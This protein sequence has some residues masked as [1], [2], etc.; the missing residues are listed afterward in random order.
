MSTLTNRESVERL[1]H[2]HEE[3]ARAGSGGWILYRKKGSQPNKI[4]TR[5]PGDANDHNLRTG[6]EESSAGIPQPLSQALI[7]GQGTASRVI[8]NSA[9]R[10]ASSSSASGDHGPSPPARREA[11]CE[12]SAASL[13]TRSSGTAYNFVAAG[14][15]PVNTLES[16]LKKPRIFGGSR[17]LDESSLYANLCRWG[18]SLF[19]VANRS[20]R[21]S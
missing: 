21:C 18:S 9:S 7:S 4:G 3:T 19:Q 8:S 5:L 20:L 13:A 14:G 6:G 15:Q 17:T 12:R 11:K 1:D 16:L 2:I 10:R